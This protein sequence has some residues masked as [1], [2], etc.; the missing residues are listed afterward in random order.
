[1]KKFQ[2]GFRRP[3]FPGA[4][5]YTTPYTDFPEELADEKEIFARLAKLQN[6]TSEVEWRLVEVIT[7]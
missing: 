1:M 7:K 5:D 2:L 4:Q 3:A 6:L